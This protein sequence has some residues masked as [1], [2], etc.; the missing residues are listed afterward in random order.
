MTARLPSPAPAAPRIDWSATRLRT[1]PAYE[2]VLFDRLSESERESLRSLAEDPECYGVLRPRA[3]SKLSLKAVS[4]DTALLL[5]ALQ[6]P[7]VLPRFAAQ[8]LGD[9]CA[10]TIGSM[11]LDGILQIEIEGATISGPEA[12]ESIY[13]T[14]PRAEGATHLATLSRRA[15]AYAASLPLEDPLELSARLYA[16]NTIPASSRWRSVLPAADATAE[17]LGLRDGGLRGGTGALSPSNTWG[18]RTETQN[19]ISFRA[20]NAK[21]TS[22]QV[23]APSIGYKLYVSPACDR[24]RDA[25][26]AVAE[27][28]AH[29]N[30]LQWKVGRGIH[31]L[32]RPDKMVVYFHHFAD[33]QEVALKIMDRLQGCAS[34][35]VPFTAELTGG[36]LLS[37]GVD[38]PGDAT[39]ELSWLGGESWRGKVCNRLAAALVHA[40]NCNREEGKGDSVEATNA[41]QFATQRLRLEGIDTDT[42]TPT[43]GFVWAS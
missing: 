33:L 4:R 15:I 31:G 3:D 9:D 35:G 22:A 34:H 41:A 32:L 43:H 39:R 16:Y 25:V 40:Q 23:S 20:I 36:G 17:Y 14:A 12:A 42:W 38:P 11:V 28:V 6:Q 26:E 24:V 37:W 1:N 27:A 21:L 2:L 30:A 7:G 18:D 5:F 29:S 10:A 13:G 19:W 8:M